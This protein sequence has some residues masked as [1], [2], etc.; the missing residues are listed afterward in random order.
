MSGATLNWTRPQVLEKL[1][2]HGSLSR[3]EL[4]EITGWSEQRLHRGLNLAC[5]PRGP[6]RKERRG[7]YRLATAEERQVPTKPRGVK[8]DSL[9]SP[10]R[11]RA[12]LTSGAQA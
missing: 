3:A 8:P 12:H 4:L 6:V 11:R 9:W 5:G 1:L 7:V 10:A 2:Q